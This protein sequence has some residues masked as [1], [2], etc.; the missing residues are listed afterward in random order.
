MIPRRPSMRV[1]GFF[2]VM[3]V[4]AACIAGLFLPRQAGAVPID[5][6]TSMPSGT[7]AVNVD[8]VSGCGGSAAG[9]DT[10][11]S[12]T[13][14]PA[15]APNGAVD[16]RPVINATSYPVHDAAPVQPS[17]LYTMPVTTPAPGPTSLLGNPLVAPT[18]LPTMNFSLTSPTSTNTASPQPV[19]ATLPVNAFE[20]G[21]NSS[22]ASTWNPAVTD[23][24][25]NRA[26]QI[27]GHGGVTCLGTVTDASTPV[28]TAQ[29]ARFPVNA[30]EHVQ[31]GSNTIPLITCTGNQPTVP[32]QVTTATDTTVL[33]GSAGKIIYVCGLMAS[34]AGVNTGYWEQSTSATCASGFT[35]V[36]GSY[37]LASSS[38]YNFMS[39]F[40]VFSLTSGDSLCWHST[41]TGGTDLTALLSQQ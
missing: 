9:G 40:A 16:V 30:L 29:V 7:P 34:G 26:V 20:Y 27:C 3:F 12:P 11:V 18:E 8:C 22:S 39:P 23:T 38:G 4:F 35:Q 41:S 1:H 10:I 17:P 6:P 21:A 15:G 13:S 19:G 2:L 33:A 24:A 25:G 31:S 32:A 28:P 36:W 37:T 14:T 5:Y